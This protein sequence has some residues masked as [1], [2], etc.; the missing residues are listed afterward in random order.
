MTYIITP[1]TSG[2]ETEVSGFLTDY[3]VDAKFNTGSKQYVAD[4]TTDGTTGFDQYTNFVLINRN[5]INYII[6]KN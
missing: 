3:F 1:T 4:K 5:N 6:W 2:E